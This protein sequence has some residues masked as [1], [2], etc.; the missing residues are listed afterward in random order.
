MPECRH[1]LAEQPMRG[2]RVR[3]HDRLAV[4]DGHL[5]GRVFQE[6]GG[7]EH[8]HEH[9]EEPLDPGPATAK[10]P[11][12]RE[13]QEHEHREAERRREQ[14]GRDPRGQLPA[15]PAASFA[16]ER[17]PGVRVSDE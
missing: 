1:D 10:T 11:S 15:R 12:G 3:E 6:V 13:E 2:E 14:R 9:D 17:E 5:D 7:H 8:R 16:H 4:R